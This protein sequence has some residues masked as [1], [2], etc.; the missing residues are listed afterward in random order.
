M[1][2]EQRLIRNIRKAAGPRQL[3]VWQGIVVSVEG[4][5]CTVEFGSQQISG[6]RL[7][8][9]LA[10]V[11]EQLLVVPKA[12]S[13]VVVG[14]LSGDLSDLAVLVVDEAERIEIGGATLGG[15]VNIEPLI[16]G[17]NALVDAYNRHTHAVQVGGVVVGELANT[18]PVAIPKT[19]AQAQA[20]DR[21]K[22]EDT[23]VQH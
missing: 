3:S 4:T 9:S 14:S 18:A 7:R 15:L 5:T 1:T 23:R 8:A 11:E 16:D 19:L 12:G 21:E 10:D 2:P 13:A 17:L 20:F 6:V 22:L